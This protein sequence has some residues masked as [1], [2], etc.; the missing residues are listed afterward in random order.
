MM[1]LADV[2]QSPMSTFL[3]SMTEIA[4]WFFGQAAKVGETVV[5]TP[6]LLVGVSLTI[7]GG[8]V[9]LFFRFVNH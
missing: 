5:S 8:A 1:I 9:G 4:T 7:I 3:S 2:V 6:L